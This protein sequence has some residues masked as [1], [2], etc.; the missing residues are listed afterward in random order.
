MQ[1]TLKCPACRAELYIDTKRNAAG[2]SLICPH[3]STPVTVN[4]D[5]PRP[6]VPLMPGAIQNRPGVPRPPVPVPTV[7]VPHAPVSVNPPE[8]TLPG[9]GTEWGKLIKI[10][11]IFLVI[12]VVL[13]GI[14]AFFSNRDANFNESGFHLLRID[15]TPVDRNGKSYHLK[16]YGSGHG[17]FL[18][19]ECLRDSYNGKIGSLEFKDGLANGEV[20]DSEYLPDNKNIKLK[21]NMPSMKGK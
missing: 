12:L 17:L 6:P 4:M 14:A 21:P 19:A 20:I 10:S 15:K 5:L 2:S 9:S 1:Y 11:L 18:R 3:C 8:N 7:A 13:T 16:L